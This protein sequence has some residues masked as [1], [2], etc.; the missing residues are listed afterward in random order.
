MFVY[1]VKMFDPAEIIAVYSTL[2]KA[3][4]SLPPNPNRTWTIYGDGWVNDIVD[5]KGNLESNMEVHRY[6]VD[7]E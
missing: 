5:T 2:G 6:E 1:I 3:M 4:D 7:K